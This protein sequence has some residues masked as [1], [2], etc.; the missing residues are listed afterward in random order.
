MKTQKTI[1][2]ALTNQIQFVIQKV[3]FPI[4]VSVKQPQQEISFKGFRDLEKCL[5]S[6]AAVNIKPQPVKLNVKLQAKT[7]TEQI[8]FN[9]IF[10]NQSKLLREIIESKRDEIIEQAN[11]QWNN[12]QK[13]KNR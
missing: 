7:Q 4:V 9:T 5:N 1:I 11:N 6:I 2:A 12:N 13:N 10:K 3:K 8:D